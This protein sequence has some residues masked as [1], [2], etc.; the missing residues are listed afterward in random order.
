MRRLTTWVLPTALLLGLAMPPA[1]QAAPHDGNWSVLVITEKGDCDRAYRYSTSVANGQV[2]YAGD[3]AVNM[4]GTVA[5]D[6]RCI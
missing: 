2:S 4:T 3:A 5:P 6:T 1:A